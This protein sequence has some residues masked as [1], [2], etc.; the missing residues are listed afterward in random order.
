MS[1]N[2]DWKYIDRFVEIRT[3]WLKIIGEKYLVETLNQ[4]VDY[5]RVE[6]PDS[7]VI[8]PICNQQLIFPKPIFRPGAGR[9]TLDFPGGR[10][11]KNKSVKESA[12]IILCRELDIEN[13]NFIDIDL[14]MINSRGLLINSSFSNQ[15]LYGFSAKI[16]PK[17]AFE[18]DENIIKYDVTKDNIYK[19]FNEF[20]CLQCRSLLMEYWINN[21]SETTTTI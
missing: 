5:W 21:I 10:L 8:V 4:E 20:E 13:T 1:T 16:Y 18:K 19:I 2:K 11:I 7:I 3:P 12:K 9:M 6:K 15:K 14:S 17:T